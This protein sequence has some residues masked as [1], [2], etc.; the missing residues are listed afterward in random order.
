MITD[1][2]LE[3][4]LEDPEGAVVML[5]ASDPECGAYGRVT[6]DPG[7][8]IEVRMFG[9]PRL[10]PGHPEEV[11]GAVGAVLRLGFVYDGRDWV[12]SKPY[13]PALLPVAAH[14]VRRALAEAWE[15]VNGTWSECLLHVR[16]L[17]PAEVEALAKGSACDRCLDGECA[18]HPQPL[19]D[20]S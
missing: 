14:A 12:W 20:V 9:W 15:I 17:E 6:V 5:A 4:L 19:G 7:S 11:V 3:L 10:T 13:M 2:V 1:L 16:V 18:G 8:V